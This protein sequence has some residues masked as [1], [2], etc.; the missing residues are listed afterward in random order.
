MTHD[1]LPKQTEEF[2]VLIADHCVMEAMTADNVVHEESGGVRGLFV[3]VGSDEMYHFSSSIREREDCV[4]GADV[5]RPWGQSQDPVEVDDMPFL[6]R[7][8]QS[9]NFSSGAFA[10]RFNS[11]AEVTSRD[12]VGDVGFHI[13][14]DVASLENLQC[15]ATSPVTGYDAVVG[16]GDNLTDAR[17]RYHDS[18][19]EPIFAMVEVCCHRGIFSIEPGTPVV[20]GSPLLKVILCPILFGVC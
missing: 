4:I 6:L 2:G 15:F 5:F 16:T 14:E 20:Y 19:V 11:L 10:L 17:V 13:I 12:M 18:V 8:I 9:L 3:L 1:T 7:Y